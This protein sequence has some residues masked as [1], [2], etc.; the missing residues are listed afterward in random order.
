MC[1]ARIHLA[2]VRREGISPTSQNV[3]RQVDQ[4][5]QN[6]CGGECP[7]VVSFLGVLALGGSA[8][9]QVVRHGSPH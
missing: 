7:G 5:H 2:H 9:A 8:G 6:G 4:H 1:P 3:I